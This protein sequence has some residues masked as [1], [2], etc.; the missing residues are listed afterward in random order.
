MPSTICAR[1][2]SRRSVRGA[3]PAFPGSFRGL[4]VRG[5]LG[6]VGLGFLEGS[7][8]DG[9]DA[10]PGVGE[11]AAEPGHVL[12]QGELHALG[13][14]P[15]DQVATR[16]AVAQLDDGILPADRVGR[17]VQEPRGRGAAGQGPVDRHVIPGDHVLDPDL[18]DDRQAD[19]VDAPLDGDMRMRVD[20]PGHGDQPRRLDD[21]QPGPSL[22]VW[23]DGRDLA[24]LDQDRP[25]VDGPLGHRQ[26]R[27]IL[28]QH[29]TT[30]L[31]PGRP[32]RVELGGD[33]HEGRGCRPGLGLGLLVRLGLGLGLLVRLGLG[34]G[35]GP[36]SGFGL[37]LRLRAW[38]SGRA[39]A[40]AW[41]SGPASLRVWPSV[42]LGLLLAVLRRASASASDLASGSRVSPPVERPSRVASP[43]RVPAFRPGVGSR[44][45]ARARRLAAIP[46]GRS[47][48]PGSGGLI[49][50]LSPSTITNLALACSSWNGAVKATM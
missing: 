26:D 7:V 25:A 37:G 50:N 22:D 6:A 34:L 10:H 30:G 39:C 3:G 8:D 2:S 20:D 48:A 24:V 31:D 46:A 27:G 44:L 16:L 32:V 13:G 47:S 23:S 29:G 41:A 28:D 17:A 18:G 1:A 33:V 49:S 45:A 19:L 4:P 5:P 36:A 9:L 14:V 43:G 15:D 40:R 38:A 35:S 42:G 12:A 21:G 11:A